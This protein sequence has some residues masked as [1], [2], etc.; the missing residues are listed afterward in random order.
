MLPIITAT[1]ITNC[2]QTAMTKANIGIFLSLVT[3]FLS[4]RYEI[5]TRGLSRYCSYSLRHIFRFLLQTQDWLKV[6][7]S[8]FKSFFYQEAE[9]YLVAV[10]EVV[11]GKS[12]KHTFGLARY[13]SSCADKSIEGICFF[14]LSL[15][16]VSTKTSYLLNVLQVVYTQEDKQII[17]EKKEKIK[18][19]KKR[20][21]EGK[22]LP[23][24]RKTNAS[25]AASKAAGEIQAPKENL[26]ASFRV[27]KELFSSVLILLR[28]LMPAIK[29][30]YLV[31]DSAYSGIDYLKVAAMYGCRLITKMKSTASLY[32]PAEKVVNKPGVTGIYGQK[33]DTENMPVAFLK[34]TEKEGSRTHQYYQ[35]S[36][37][38]KALP[39][40][41]LNIVVL[42]TTDQKGRISTNIWFTNDED[43]SYETLLQYY[44]MRFQIEYHF[45]DAKQHFGLSDFKNYKQAN[46]TNFVNLSFTMDLMSSI[47]LQQC[48]AEFENPKL[49]IL[50]LK[51]IFNAHFTAKKVIKLLRL[52]DRNNFYS[53]IIAKFIPTDIINKR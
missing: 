46:L 37:Y 53:N 4:V 38:N 1:T 33:I 35:F 27:F 45:R 12:G 23:K 14:A 39:G 44:S 15:I 30:P 40:V 5:T 52:D 20:T 31:A 41:L 29:I 17:A 28:D 47:I 13:Y 19:G 24:G 51:I 48:R 18:E 49:S 8:L 34:K 10:D 42:I 36:A 11:E 3:S 22:N 26:T 50:D 21:K 32:L 16:K 9:V 2:L 43:I 25:K 7:V 6:R